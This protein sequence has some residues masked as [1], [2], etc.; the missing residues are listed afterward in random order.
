MDKVSIIIPTF[1]RFKYVM[2]AIESMKAQT[3]TNIEIIVVNDCST[4]HAYYDFNWDGVTIVHLPKNTKEMFGFACAGYVRNRGI[5][6]STGRYVAFCDDDDIWFPQ[7]LELQLNAMKQTGC[8]MSS[9]D[10]LIG[11]GPYEPTKTYSKYQQYFNFSNLPKIWDFSL[12]R[13]HNY[14]ITSSV[15][16]DKTFLRAIGNFKNVPNGQEDYGCW[17]QAL[18]FTTNV[19]IDE[20]CFYYD[21]GHGYGR[22][23]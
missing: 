18:H 11:E 14:I 4:E 1:N 17:L 8:K 9:T 21:T 16:I 13:Q 7:K 10:G 3:Y 20:A 19:Y 15:V 6:V 12:I 2:N 23:Y 5:E 22:N